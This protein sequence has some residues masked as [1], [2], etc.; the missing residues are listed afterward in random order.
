MYEIEYKTI[1]WNMMYNYIGYP[2]ADLLIDVKRASGG[3]GGGSSLS[4]F[5]DDSRSSAVNSGG[6]F[7]VLARM[8]TLD[9]PR[10]TSRIPCG[11]VLNV[12][13]VACGIPIETPLA[14]AS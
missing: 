1:Y 7:S 14:I 8:T 5:A 12:H 2:V 11:V 9:A 6:V 3:G 13:A 10:N 4:K